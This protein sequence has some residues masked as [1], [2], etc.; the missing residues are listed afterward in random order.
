[1]RLFVGN[2]FQRRVPVLFILVIVWYAVMGAASP[3]TALP[4]SHTSH[5][6]H[7]IQ[8]AHIPHSSKHVSGALAHLWGDRRVI[9]W[10]HAG[11]PTNATCESQDNLACYSPLEMRNIYNL[12]SLLN[13]GF[14]GQ[15]Q[16]IVIINSFGSPTI[17][18]DLHQFDQ[19]YGLQDPPSFKILAPLGTV[20]FDASNQ[21]QVGWAQE[22][23]LDV[24]WSHVMAPAANIVLLTS[25]VSETQGVQGMPEFLKLEQYAVNN[26][27][28]T[29][30]SQSWGTTE[31]TLLTPAGRQILDGFNTFYQQ[32][33][34]NEH[35]T[36]IASAGDAGVVNPDVDDKN[37]PFPT[38]EFPASSPWVT[39]VGGSTLKVDQYG[40][41]ASESVWNNGSGSASGGGYSK[42]FHNLSYQ[43][44][45]S[46]PTAYSSNGYR[47]LPDIAY[48]ADPNTGVP[49][50]MSFMNQPDSYFV[51]GGTSAGS[52][53]WAGMI[54]DANQEAQAP[55]GFINAKLYQLGRFTIFANLAF[56]DITVGNNNQG[57]ITGYSAASGWDAASGWGSPDA[58]ILLD[59]LASSASSD[60]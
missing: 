57:N 37:Y 44:S 46:Q 28:G 8:K 29:I 3:E 1:M 25:P 51:I 17:T 4:K 12:T 60:G 16:T 31:E 52:P 41:Y 40:N 6:V 58:T 21:D 54:A 13:A 35:I 26:H 19:D 50:Y 34:L 36:F 49:V 18:N 15:R 20:P 33:T 9:Q 48:D 27:L 42:Y 47:A 24:E 38:V 39:A 32:A 59:L 7:K 55:L 22:T 10:R 23:S 56:H 2:V 45:S 53:Q 43:Q 14:D 11:A 5:S 30:I